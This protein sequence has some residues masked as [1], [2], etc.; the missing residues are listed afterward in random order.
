M[1][2]VLAGCGAAGGGG[3]TATTGERARPP[4]AARP[5][6]RPAPR[7][8]RPVARRARRPPTVVASGIPFPTNLA[9]EEEGR[10]WGAS[11]AGGPNASDGVWFVP[12]RGRPRHVA[13]DLTTA[14]GLRWAGGRL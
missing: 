5:R 13:R 11:G 6:A 10:L 8:P 2:L 12:R 14:L 3:S 7:R 9:F 1:A 4:S